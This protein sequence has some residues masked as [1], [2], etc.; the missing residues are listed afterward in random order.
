MTED[1]GSLLASTTTMEVALVRKK[2]RIGFQPGTR[3]VD[4]VY[5]LNEFPADA[6]LVE[7]IDWE[8]ENIL[9]LE[10]QSEVEQKT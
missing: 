8:D 10:F 2:Y 4:M 6:R 3:V 7:F 1:R 5:R 9:T